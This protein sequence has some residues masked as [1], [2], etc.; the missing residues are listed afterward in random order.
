MIS[1][2]F[3]IFFILFQSGLVF[4]IAGQDGSNK[5]YIV[6]KPIDLHGEQ[7]TIPFGTVI[8]F[9]GNGAFGNGKII[10]NSTLVIAPK[11]GLVFKSDVQ[12][13]GSWRADVAYSNWFDF[14]DDCLLGKDGRYQSGSDNYCQMNN[15]LTFDNLYFLKGTYCFKTS[16][17]QIRSNSVINGNGSVFKSTDYTA[18]GVFFEL[19]SSNKRVP[20]II[21]NVVLKDFTIIGSKLESTVITEQC[22]GIAIRFGAKIRLENINSNL[23]R[24]DGLY[25][26]NSQ[27]ESYKDYSPSG[28]EV[29]NCIFDS[30]HR[31]GSSITRANGVKYSKCQFTNTNGTAPQSGLDIEPNAIDLSQ[32]TDCNYKCENISIDSCYFANNS[33]NGLLIPAARNIE[34]DNYLI[35]NVRVTNCTF[36][37]DNIRAFGLNGL[38]VENCDIQTSN[39]GWITY[40][41]SSKNIVV[42]N[43]RITNTVANNNFVGIRIATTSDASTQESFTISNCVISNFGKAGILVDSDVNY[44]SFHSIISGNKFKKCKVTVQVGTKIGSVKCTDN[45]SEQR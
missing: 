44:D 39:Y 5:Q 3:L 12:L 25:I 4:S 27:I 6:D 41:F 7:I 22:H 18:T 38:L 9:K 23:N 17:F 32:Y 10:G 1:R 37:N 36:S 14:K 19:G 33:G 45:V 35:E 34:N 15:M 28:I 26:G 11:N 21:S 2:L 43:C 29:V 13:L 30:N 42:N 40:R 8:V 20:A 24:G 16:N 31:Q